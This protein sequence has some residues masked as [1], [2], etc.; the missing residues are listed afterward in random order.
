[1][2]RLQL[3]PAVEL[4]ATESRSEQRC[5][6]DAM[7]TCQGRAFWAERTAPA[8]PQHGSVAACG[9]GGKQAGAGGAG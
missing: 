1:M 6:E 7:A 4:R 9:E 3:R 8:R 2:G 5:E